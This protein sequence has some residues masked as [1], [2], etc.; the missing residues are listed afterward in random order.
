MGIWVWVLKFFFFCWT[1]EPSSIRPT[2]YH[3]YHLPLSGCPLIVWYMIRWYILFISTEQQTSNRWID[4]HTGHNPICGVAAC[5]TWKKK[6]CG[7][8]ISTESPRSRRSA[9]VLLLLRGAAARGDVRF[10]ADGW[11]SNTVFYMSIVPYFVG[12]IKHIPDD[13]HIDFDTNELARFQKKLD[14]RK[15]K[16]RTAQQSSSIWCSVQLFVMVHVASSVF[17]INSFSVA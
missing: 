6:I 16:R 17:W 8:K 4:T 2:P 9:C 13:G 10:V 14:K 5:C 3:N 15:K 12:K 1:L 11:A 7:T